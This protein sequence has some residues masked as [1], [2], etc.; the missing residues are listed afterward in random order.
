MQS[1]Q[2]RAKVLRGVVAGTPYTAMDVF[3]PTIEFISGP[4]NPGAKYGYLLGTPEQ[5]AAVGIELSV[6]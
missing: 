6:A 4:D 5:N 1:D 3:G 2:N